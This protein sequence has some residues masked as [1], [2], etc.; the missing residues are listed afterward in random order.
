MEKAVEKGMKQKEGEKLVHSLQGCEE[1][2]ASRLVPELH[3]F[4]S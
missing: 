4:K 1:S 3:L 2:H